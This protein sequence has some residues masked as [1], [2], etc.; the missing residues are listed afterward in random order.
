MMTLNEL[1]KHFK[2]LSDLEG[3]AREEEEFREAFK[4]A[5]AGKAPV[6]IEAVVDPTEYDVII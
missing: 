2:F 1:L 4:K 3:F 6:V 5:L